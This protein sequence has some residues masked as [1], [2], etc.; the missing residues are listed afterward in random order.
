[1][2]NLSK[3]KNS[4]PEESHPRDLVGRVGTGTVA[5]A[6]TQGWAGSPGSLRLLD[7]WLVFYVSLVGSWAP[8][9][10]KLILNLLSVVYSCIYPTSTC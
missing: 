4:V 9:T 2:I 3:R 5:E 10:I 1:M 6:T 7:F 8:D